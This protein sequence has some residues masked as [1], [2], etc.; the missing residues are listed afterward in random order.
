MIGIKAWR[1]IVKQPFEGA[2][3][4][5]VDNSTKDIQFVISGH[6]GINL[7]EYK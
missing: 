4:R 3:I 5:Q 2:D 7:I 6:S 1:Q